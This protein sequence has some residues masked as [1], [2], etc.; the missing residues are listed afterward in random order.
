MVH[1]LPI[2]LYTRSCTEVLYLRRGVTICPGIR[3]SN[4]YPIPQWIHNL[5]DNLPT[6]EHGSR[7]STSSSSVV[8]HSYI[9][10]SKLLTAVLKYTYSEGSRPRRMK[11]L[12]RNKL[13]C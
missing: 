3:P 1:V 10:M 12:P 2:A 6:A 8:S 9:M 7:E 4:P 11:C 13:R 5:L